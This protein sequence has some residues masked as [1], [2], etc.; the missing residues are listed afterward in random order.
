[1]TGAQATVG[2]AIQIR[3]RAGDLDVLE[4]DPLTPGLRFMTT[5]LISTS[6]STSSSSSSLPAGPT[7]TVAINS[8]VVPK[9]SPSLKTS[10]IYSTTSS[11]SSSPS[12]SITTTPSAFPSDL[13]PT[14]PPAKS[15]DT[16]DRTQKG[17]D[18]SGSSTFTTATIVLTAILITILAAYGA[19]AM[20]KRYRRYRAGETTGTETESGPELFVFQVEA[21]VRRL[22]LRL[23]KNK[24]TTDDDGL[25]D[26]DEGK[27]RPRRKLPDAELGTNGPLPELAD[28]KPFGTK[29]NPAELPSATTT[30]E[31]ISGWRERVT[32]MSRL[33][34]KHMSAP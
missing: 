10:T 33:F 1:M 12:D 27:G 20:L 18:S 19:W 28:T 7:I 22:L 9:P 4:T 31:R 13:S 17:Q 23:N 11:L 8:P 3:W 26:E 16:P 32:R 6:I 21:W 14:G 29:E 30:Q 24:T 5:S 34:T 2:P 15:Q 25:E